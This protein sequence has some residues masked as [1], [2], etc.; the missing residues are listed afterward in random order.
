MCHIIST[1]SYFLPIATARRLAY[2]AALNSN[3]HRP[4]EM[5]VVDL[6]P[7]STTYSQLPGSTCLV[8]GTNNLRSEKGTDDWAK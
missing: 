5:T 7:G 4:D 8:F 6:D 2:V 1:R 3:E